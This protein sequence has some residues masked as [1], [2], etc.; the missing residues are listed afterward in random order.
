M[1]KMTTEILKRGQ[2]RGRRGTAIARR[3]IKKGLRHARAIGRSGWD[4]VSWAFDPDAE[5]ACG[6][7]MGR[8]HHAQAWEG[9]APRPMNDRE[10]RRFGQ[11]AGWMQAQS[12]ARQIAQALADNGRRE[13]RIRRL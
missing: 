13:R 3:A 2:G 5:M 7:L 6:R 12:E 8:G 1:Q 9:R 11:I 4:F 10:R